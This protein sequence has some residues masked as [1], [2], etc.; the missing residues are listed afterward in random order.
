[1]KQIIPLLLAVSLL[2]S[3]CGTWLDGNYSNVTPH[4]EN[5]TQPDTGNMTATTYSDLV[6]ALEQMILF[7]TES[8]VIP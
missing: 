6:A 3:G 8:G 4:K 2:L 7:C 5:I 1:M